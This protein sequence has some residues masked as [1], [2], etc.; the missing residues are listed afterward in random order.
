MMRNLFEALLAAGVTAEVAGKAA[1]EVA[2]YENRLA[3]VETKLAVLQWM[4][5]FNLAISVAIAF[6]VFV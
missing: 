5:G 6:K 2:V 1:E 3:S 4:V